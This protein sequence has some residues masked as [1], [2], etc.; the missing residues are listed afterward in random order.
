[1]TSLTNILLN[2]LM[3]D[4]RLNAIQLKTTQTKPIADAVV[5]RNPISFMYYGIKKGRDSVKQGKRMNVEPFAIGMSKKGKLLLRAYVPSPN[6]SKKG[7]NDGNHWRT[8]QMSNMRNVVINTESTFG[9]RPGYHPGEED[10]RG[11]MASILV[12]TDFNAVPKPKKQAKPKATKLKVAKE[13]PVKPV[14]EPEVK[15]TEPTAQPTAEPTTPETLPQPT[16]K[17]KPSATPPTAKTLAEPK[18]EETPTQEPAA[19]VQPTEPPAPEVNP[20]EENNNKLQESIN[21]IKTL[22]LF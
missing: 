2:E 16:P 20:E 19:E 10:K 1:M 11:P 22:M 15:P 13:K 6:T 12:S 21:R 9:E 17:Q 3:S 4:K 14:A 5:N 18:P 8:F 7:F